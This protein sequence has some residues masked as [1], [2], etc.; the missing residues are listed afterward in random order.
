MPAPAKRMPISL[1]AAAAPPEDVEPFTSPPRVGADA[2]LEGWF[3]QHFD[4]LW[5]LAR[6]LGVPHALVDDVV[7][8]AFITA[9]RRAADILEG[10]ERRFLINTTVKLSANCRRR[11]SAQELLLGPLALQTEPP[12]DAEQ[13]LAGKQSRQVLDRVL[14]QMPEDQ[15]AVFV[16]YE[17]EG[18]SVPEI[19]ELL[20]LPLGTVASRLG[21]G[22]DKFSKAAARL[23]ARPNDE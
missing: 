5:R 23:R 13:L 8:E 2:R 1:L 11:Q 10:S 12:P 14:E 18:F 16:L 19:A 21:R 17:L 7:Q 20:E 15:R 9:Q 22:R 6:R 4:P 3:R